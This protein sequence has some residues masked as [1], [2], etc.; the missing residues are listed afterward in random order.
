M[1]Y[2]LHF[3]SKIVLNHLNVSQISAADTLLK[4]NESKAIT[5]YLNFFEIL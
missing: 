3:S 2:I 4:T 1:F 5:I